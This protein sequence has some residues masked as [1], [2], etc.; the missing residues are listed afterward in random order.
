MFDW[1]DYS[2]NVR[3]MVILV[4]R[5]TALFKRAIAKTG[6]VAILVRDV[7]GVGDKRTF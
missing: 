7:Q 3:K 2:T 5:N 1:K 4:Y 6:Q